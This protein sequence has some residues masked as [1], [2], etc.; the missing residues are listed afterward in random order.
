MLASADGTKVDLRVVSH[1]A[2]WHIVSAFGFVLF[3]AFN[4]LCLHGA[5]PATAAESARRP[6]GTR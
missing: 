6:S 5:V 2:L 3:W 4:D 1:H